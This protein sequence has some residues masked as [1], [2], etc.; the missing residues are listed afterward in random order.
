MAWARAGCNTAASW[1]VRARRAPRPAVY[2]NRDGKAEVTVFRPATAEWFSLVNT[3]PWTELATVKAG[4]PG[5]VPVPA[6]YNGDGTIERATWHAQMGKWSCTE[7]GRILCPVR[8][9]R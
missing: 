8:G 7:P 1:L 3:N 9:L 5:S 6:D 2:I 4:V